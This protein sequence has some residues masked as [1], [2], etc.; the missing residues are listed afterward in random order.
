MANSKGSSIYFGKHSQL[1]PKIPSP[2]VPQSYSDYVPNSII[3]SNVAQKPREGH[4]NLRRTSSESLVNVIEEQP[5]WLDDLLN[6]PETPVRRG[7]HRRSSS[8]SF[9]YTD[10]FNAFNISRTDQDEYKYKNSTSIPSWASLDIDNGKV[11]YQIPPYAEMNSVKQKNRAWE[12][13]VNAVT[14]PSGPH[15][16]DNVALQSPGSS[17]A[18]READGVASAVNEKYE[19]VDPGV[20]DAKSSARRKDGSHAKPSASE[21]DTKRAKQQFAQRSR[22]RKLQYIAELERNVQ[23]LQVEGNEVSA[24]LDFLNQRNLIL[25]M[26]NNALKQ[27]LENLTQEQLIKYMEYEVLEREVGRLRSIYQQQQQAQHLPPQQS[28]SGLRRTKSRD[29]ESQFAN[30]S[31]KHKESSSERDSVTGPLRS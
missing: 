26:E 31:M 29:L 13:S 16:R 8:D 5:S 7:G 10:T 9:A 19:S 18:S 20:Q 12:S 17:C 30:L 23:A 25:S 15:G 27:R 4:N 6:E 22:V 14:H 28:S 3:G 1:P 21:T 2:S 11:A 24:E